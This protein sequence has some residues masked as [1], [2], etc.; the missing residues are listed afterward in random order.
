MVGYPKFELSQEL[1]NILNIFLVFA[2]F[3]SGLNIRVLKIQNYLFLII[4]SKSI[5][6]HCMQEHKTMFDI[7]E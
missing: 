1:F 4:H 5:L 2:S 6:I 3:I 7:D